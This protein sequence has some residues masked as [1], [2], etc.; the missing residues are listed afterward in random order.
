MADSYLEDLYNNGMQALKSGHAGKALDYF[1]EL[2]ELDRTPLNCTLF[3]YV[4]ALAEGNVKKGI[5]LCKEA[6]KREPKS[7]IHFLYLGRIHLLAGQKKDAIRIFRMGLR[8]ERN[9]EINAE[10]SEL[11][12]RKEPVFPF[13]ARENPLNQFFGRTLTRMGLR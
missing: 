8:L 6:I 13:L 3:G 5:S 4:L 9:A 2:I 12:T 7:S 11:G 10:L 1:R